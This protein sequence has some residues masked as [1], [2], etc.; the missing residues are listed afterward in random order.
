[1]K[2]AVVLSLRHI[3]ALVGLLLVLLAPATGS[4]Q[5]ASPPPPESGALD[6]SQG[7]DYD[8]WSATASRAEEAILSGRASNAAFETLRAQIADWREVFLEAQNT[9]KARIATIQRQLDALGPAPGEGES[10][11]AEIAERRKELNAQLEK[12]RAPVV[13]AEEAHARANGLISEIDRVIRERQSRELLSRG[14]SPLNPVHWADTLAQL[15][16]TSGAI[17]R[18]V[19]SAWSSSVQRDRFKSELPKTLLLMLVGI[20][21]LL[22]GR[23][24][25]KRMGENAYRKLHRGR[26]VWEFLISLGQVVLPLL[27]IVALEEAFFSSGLVGL[28][29]TVIID[30]LSRWGATLLIGWWLAGRLFPDGDKQAPVNIG[31]SYRAG[32][33]FDIAALSVLLVVHD[34]L[35]RVGDAVE[36]TPESEAV[37]GFPIIILSALLLYRLTHSLRLSIGELFEEDAATS[38]HLIEH[39]YRLRIIS[40]LSRL[41]I[42]VAFAAP[43]MA[44]VGYNAA[45]NALIYPSILTLGL[46]GTVLILQQLVTDLY[47]LVMKTEEGAGEALLPVVVGFLLTLA[48]FPVVA[49]IWGARVTSLQEIWTQ[50]REGFSIGGTR[51]SPTDFL[52]FALVFVMGYV[53]TRMVQGALR[54]SVLPKTRLDQGGQNA[55]VAGMGYVGI[56]LAAVI[57]I[58]AAGIDL[59]SL[60]I[61]AGALS[62]GIGFGLQ[63]IVSNFVSGI[64]LL[65]ERPISEG[66]WIEVGGQHGNVRSISVRSTRIE[67]FDRTDVIVPNADL[68]SGTVT[69]YTR[70]NTVGRVIVPVGVAYGSDTRKI[71]EILLEVA[72]AHPMVAL[73]PAPYVLFRGFGADSLEFEIRAILRDV[74]WIMNV[75]SDM[76][77]QIAARFAEEGIEIPFAQRDVWLRN[78][79]VLKGD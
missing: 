77:H 45:A 65:I 23:A 74:N 36:F 59:S 70:G 18:E 51:V 73:N 7:P 56:F 38:E 58:T 68:I 35:A 5:D 29:G 61:V 33:R 15:S 53:L 26:E 21:L 43:L 46:F 1:M 57:A 60:A 6:A 42:L 50:F 69:N 79:E 10:E 13:A 4:A 52:T 64:I 32:I 48:A 24:W 2:P 37:A 72:K 63:N 11:A 76:N 54:G 55:I 3:P 34:V 19:T 47:S 40:A 39:N 62:V 25:A 14:P 30:G 9:N 49:L 8:Q 20:V 27:G 71:E 16:G 41:G 22:R 17:V 75:H 78:P 66:D 44:A 31:E 12:L 67:T 28:R